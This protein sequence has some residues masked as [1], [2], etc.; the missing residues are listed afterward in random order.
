MPVGKASFDDDKLMKNFASVMEAIM[1]AKP[2]GL[3]GN[4]L[5]RVVL[6]STMGPGVKVDVNAASALQ[7]T[8][9]E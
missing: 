2:A 8:D 3:K 7:A 4:Y 9:Y 1:A 5:H 6:T